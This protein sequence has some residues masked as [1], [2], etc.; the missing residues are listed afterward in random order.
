M[1]EV[2]LLLRSDMSGSGSWRSALFLAVIMIIIGPLQMSANNIT[3]QP[4]SID[5]E[6]IEIPN[7]TSVGAETIISLPGD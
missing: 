1:F 3:N 7:F 6:D 5:L 2:L 4:L